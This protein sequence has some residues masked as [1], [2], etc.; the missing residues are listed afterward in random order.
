VVYNADYPMGDMPL[1]LLREAGIA[2]RQ[3]KMDKEK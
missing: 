2:V 1:S 3:V